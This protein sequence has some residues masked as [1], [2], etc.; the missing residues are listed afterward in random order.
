M[1]TRFQKL[2]ITDCQQGM[3]DSQEE[4]DSP[5]GLRAGY[6]RNVDSQAQFPDVHSKA[7]NV[8]TTSNKR[9]HIEGFTYQSK[10]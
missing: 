5:C 4:W 2:T 8:T 10:S 6:A 9:V 7:S 1:S 3:F